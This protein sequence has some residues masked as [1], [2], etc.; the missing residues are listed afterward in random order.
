MADAPQA[1]PGRVSF[2]R[3]FLRLVVC[4]LAY[5]VAVGCASAVGTF[6][7]Y[8]GLEAEQVDTVTF[9][10]TAILGFMLV[11]AESLLAAAVA[12]ILTEAFA[13]RAVVVHLL[14]GAGIGVWLFWM[15]VGFGPAGTPLI[16]VLQGDRR[17]LI[18]VASGVA[19]GFVYWLL[20]GRSAGSYR[21]PRYLP[22]GP[23]A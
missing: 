11:V 18:A 8:R 10:W 3:I 2:T 5:F 13:V 14:L 9:A 23:D 17:L 15:A 16:D 7:L 4:S 6:A 20:A 22:A 19:G 1:V 21:E 12:I